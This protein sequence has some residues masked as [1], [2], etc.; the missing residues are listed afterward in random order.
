[1]DVDEAV[2]ASFRLDPTEGL[3]LRRAFLGVAS[4]AAELASLNPFARLTDSL[5]AICE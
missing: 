4:G 3:R 5:D 1:M 2:R